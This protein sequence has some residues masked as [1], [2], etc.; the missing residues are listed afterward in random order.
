MW[1]P[2]LCKHSHL[3][4]SCGCSMTAGGQV[5]G[6]SRSQCIW[7]AALG[8][9]PSSSSLP[10]SLSLLWRSFPFFFSL[11]SSPSS[12]TCLI[13]FFLTSSFF[14]S[15]LFSSSP[16]TV[17]SVYS[18]LSTLLPITLLS[19]PPPFL[20]PA[21]GNCKELAHQEYT[22]TGFEYFLWWE[23]RLREPLRSSKSVGPSS[24]QCCLLLHQSGQ[25]LS[26]PS[27][28][29][30]HIQTS[31]DFFLNLFCSP[32]Q[33]SPGFGVSHLLSN[34]GRGQ[35][36]GRGQQRGGSLK[37]S[38]PGFQDKL[39]T[40]LPRMQRGDRPAYREV[41]RDVLGLQ[42][43]VLLRPPTSLI[44]PGAGGIKGDRRVS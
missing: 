2:G 12:L 39:E 42:A 43:S 13:F 5:A 30:G 19:S 36:R 14:L 10:P 35:W 23:R 6:C 41:G 21:A 28:E 16:F 11:V 34:L 38:C 3:H 33:H 18:I 7:G 20:P 32:R 37:P 1:F 27:I 40:T 9:F 22:N 44:L 29:A 31:E 4:P 26:K 24:N 25:E 8:G 17:F 15:P